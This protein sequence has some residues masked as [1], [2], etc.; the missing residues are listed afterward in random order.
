MNGFE[1]IGVLSLPDLVVQI[2]D[3]RRECHI[4]MHVMYI[5]STQQSPESAWTKARALNSSLVD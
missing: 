3:F 1:M 5:V 4:K 2:N